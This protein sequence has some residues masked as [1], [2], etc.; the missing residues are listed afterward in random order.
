MCSE[1]NCN[2]E[3]FAKGFCLMHYKRN[4][5]LQWPLCEFI[6]CKVRCQHGGLCG[7]HSRTHQSESPC[8]L[9]GC[10]VAAFSDGLCAKHYRRQQRERYGRCTVPGCRNLIGDSGLCPM[11]KRRLKVHGSV[12]EPTKKG[13]RPAKLYVSHGNTYRKITARG[14]DLAMTMAD[15]KEYVAE[16]RLVMARWLGRPLFTNETVHHRNGKTLDNR[17]ENLELW[18]SSQPPGQRPAEVLAWCH[19]YIALYGEHFG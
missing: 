1:P 17:L 9:D 16:H 15:S 3:A 4:R 19:E 12:G 6:G 11:H 10:D 2:R 18:V 8:R 13:H 5:R 14:D 7:Y